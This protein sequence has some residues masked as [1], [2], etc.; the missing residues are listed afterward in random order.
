MEGYFDVI[1]AY[2]VGVYNCVAPMGT[3]LTKNHVDIL[4]RV[5]K[6]VI[7]CFDGDKA[8]RDATERA[9]PLLVDAD[10]DVE[11]DTETIKDTETPL[12]IQRSGLSGRVWLSRDFIFILSCF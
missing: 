2:T 10:M 6:S 7:L 9:I 11:Q 12:A 3:S 8:G 5:T 4:K 1:R